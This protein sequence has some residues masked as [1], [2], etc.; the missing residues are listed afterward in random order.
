[1]VADAVLLPVCIVGM[2]RPEEVLDRAIVLAASI[3]VDDQEADR[4]PGR[5]ALEDAGEDLHGIAFATLRGVAALAG[6]AAIDPVLDVG[7]DERDFRRHAVDHA[8][9]RRAMALAERGD[10]QAVAEGVAGHQADIRAA[11]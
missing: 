2:A 1:M 6:A 8:A 5:H 3:L 11:A 10:P 4:R 7:L 9:D